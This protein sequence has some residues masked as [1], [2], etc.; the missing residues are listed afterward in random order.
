MVNA[1]KMTIEVLDFKGTPLEDMLQEV[2]NNK[3]YH[4]HKV[5][6]I[7]KAVIEDWDDDHPMNQRMTDIANVAWWQ[8]NGFQIKE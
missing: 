2:L 5:G 3:Y 8:R 4:I 7:I 1:Y 6:P